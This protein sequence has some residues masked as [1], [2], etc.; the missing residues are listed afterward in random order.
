MTLNDL[1]VRKLCKKVMISR[2]GLTILNPQ[3]SS[4]S[5]E[6]GWAWTQR[7]SSLEASHR[8][9]RCHRTLADAKASEQKMC[10]KLI[11][12]ATIWEN[13]EGLFESIWV[14]SC[15][16]L[17]IQTTLLVCFGDPVTIL[18]RYFRFDWGRLPWLYPPWLAV[19]K[20]KRAFCSALAWSSHLPWSPKQR[21]LIFVATCP[22]S[23][24][25][26]ENIEAVLLLATILADKIRTN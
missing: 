2:F 22:R 5:G 20:R 4:V 8:A 19:D 14:V 9:R 25:V 15:N 18:T 12:W 1:T 24:K 17:Q 6:S 26:G 7:S 16:H 13:I 23:V 11:K 3:K 10:F 21:S